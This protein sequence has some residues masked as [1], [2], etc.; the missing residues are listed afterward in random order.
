MAVRPVA[1]DGGAIEAF[2]RRARTFVWARIRR[3]WRRFLC[4]LF[5]HKARVVHAYVGVG[6]QGARVAGLE[7]R[8]CLIVLKPLGSIRSSEYAGKGRRLG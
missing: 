1:L 3:P 2:R 6:G 7:C 5:G 8:R 4:G